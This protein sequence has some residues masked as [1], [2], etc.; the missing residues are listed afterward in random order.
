M[1]N[2]E[3]T[4]ERKPQWRRS[5]AHRPAV[6]RDSSASSAIARS[7]FGRYVLPEVH[8]VVIELCRRRDAWYT[9]GEDG[10]YFHDEAAALELVD[11]EIRGDASL[12]VP[13]HP[14][15]YSPRA[16]GAASSAPVWGASRSGK[17]GILSFSRSRSGLWAFDLNDH[18]GPG[19]YDPFWSQLKPRASSQ[20][21]AALRSQSVRFDLVP[22][23][24]ADNEVE[25]EAADVTAD[26][27]PEDVGVSLGDR[28]VSQW[29]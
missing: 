1:T 9:R 13:P 7:W 28:L 15:K 18:G 25:T 27:A 10:Y 21:S 22:L 12:F 20:S 19:L 29:L 23:D 17:G 24:D 5:A 11:R 14:G 6:L 26:V 4:D 2:F 8:D 16:E 3:R